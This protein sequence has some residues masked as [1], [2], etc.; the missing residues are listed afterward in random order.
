MG[1]GSA[2]SADAVV[3]GWSH[4]GGAVQQLDKG[5]GCGSCKYG[6]AQ[7]PA[8]VSIDRGDVREVRFT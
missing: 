2:L 6:K 7:S 8:Q 3:L 5:V 4:R 1:G